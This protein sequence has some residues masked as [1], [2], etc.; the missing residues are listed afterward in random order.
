M[1]RKR[2]STRS[3][4]PDPPEETQIH[5]PSRPPQPSHRML[6]GYAFDSSLTTPERRARAHGPG[7]SRGFHSVG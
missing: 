7:R 3:K 1:A 6:R 5:L 2:V 4:V